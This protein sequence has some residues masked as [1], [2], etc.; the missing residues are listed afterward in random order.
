MFGFDYEFA[1]TPTWVKVVSD[2]VN[3]A[4]MACFLGNLLLVLHKTSVNPLPP[5]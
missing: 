3:R 1:V 5:P 2:R 4:P